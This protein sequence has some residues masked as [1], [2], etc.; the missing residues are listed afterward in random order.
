MLTP[1]RADVLDARIVPI[2]HPSYQAVWRARLG[3]DADGYRQA[4]SAAIDT[5]E[6]A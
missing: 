5:T 1:V 2:L 6:M 3:Y 4:V